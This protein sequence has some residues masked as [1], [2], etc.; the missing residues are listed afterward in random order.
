[1]FP[2]LRLPVPE[3]FVAT[4]LCIVSTQILGQSTLKCL[5]P[6][7]I[8][9]HPTDCSKYLEC[10]NDIVNIRNCPEGQIFDANSL[11]CGDIETSVCEYIKKPEEGQKDLLIVFDATASMGTDLAQ[12]RS[13]AIEIVNVLARKEEDPINQFILSIFRDPSELKVL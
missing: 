12:L 11:Q 3:F 1:M 7:G 6:T 8:Q 10:K 4:I 5:S 9:P 2:F 13:A